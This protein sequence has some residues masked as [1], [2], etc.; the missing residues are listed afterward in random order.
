MFL[1]QIHNKVYTITVVHIRFFKVII[2]VLIIIILSLLTFFIY[3]DLNKDAKRVG[4]TTDKK[5]VKRQGIQKSNTPYDFNFYHNGE[6]FTY[7][8]DKGQKNLYI[9]LQIEGPLK[10]VNSIYTLPV[11]LIG[12]NIDLV[13]GYADW[14]ILLSDKPTNDNFKFTATVIKDL[15]KNDSLKVNKFIRIS[16]PLSEIPDKDEVMKNPKCT[17]PCKKNIELTDKMLPANKNFFDI[18]ESNN[19]AN[20][21]TQLKIGPVSTLVLID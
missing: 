3:S 12:K 20:N 4:Q 6:Y 15:A 16:L 10:E 5:I 17:V 18:L 1:A 21:K 2:P 7:T 11:S 8:S 9:S 19:F 14:K 13:I